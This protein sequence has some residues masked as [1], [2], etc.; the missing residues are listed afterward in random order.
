MTARD[1]SG[2]RTVE[3]KKQRSKEAKKQR[4]KE[5][6]K[7]RSKEAK[8]LKYHRSNVASEERMLHTREYREEKN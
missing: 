3:A 4:S 6:K 2:R 8:K 1:F 7:Q 5:A